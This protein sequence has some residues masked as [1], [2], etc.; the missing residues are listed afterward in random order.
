MH[1]DLRTI[2]PADIAELPMHDK[3]IDVA[4]EI[5]EHLFV[6]HDRRIERDLDRLGV[7]G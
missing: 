7:A 4:P 5:V 1:E 6:G 3:R 2:L